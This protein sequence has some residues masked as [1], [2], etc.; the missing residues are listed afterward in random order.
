MIL[1]RFAS[2]VKQ[3]CIFTPQHFQSP[4]KYILICALFMDNINHAEFTMAAFLA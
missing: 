3:K 4:A 2:S 1:S